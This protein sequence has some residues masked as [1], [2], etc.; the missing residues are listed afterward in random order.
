MRQENKKSHAIAQAVSRRPVT[1]KARIRPRISPC[2]I[3]GGQSGTGSGFSPN[4]SVFPCQYYFTVALHTHTHTHT[5]LVATVHRHSL[6]SMDN[7]NDN[8]VFLHQS[9]LTLTKLL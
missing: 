9:P 5:P 3:S 7:N 4:Y 8:P 6:I 2:G 1:T